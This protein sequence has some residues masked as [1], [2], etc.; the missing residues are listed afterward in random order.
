MLNRSRLS[1]LAPFSSRR[2]GPV[3]RSVPH[4]ASALRFALAL[5]ACIALRTPAVAMAQGAS[6]PPHDS[7][8]ARIYLTWR[9]PYGQPGASY[10]LSAACGDTVAKDT[11]YMCFDPGRGSQSFHGMSATVHFWAAAGESLGGHWQFGEGQRFGGLQVELNPENVPAAGRA[12]P[13][14]GVARAHYSATSASGKL[15][16]VVAVPSTQAPAVEAGTLYCF[17]RVL[18]PRPARKSPGCDRPICI[19]WAVAGLGYGLGDEPEIRRGSRFVGWNS[20]DGKVCAPLRRPVGAWNPRKRPP[21]PGIRP[22][23]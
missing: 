5:A 1:R 14:S 7:P 21:A 20:R 10:Q 6:P 17:A 18:V 15:Q 13:S 9:A 19:E 3:P 12:W 16:M 8:G 2:T 11:L 23:R 4:A 22:A